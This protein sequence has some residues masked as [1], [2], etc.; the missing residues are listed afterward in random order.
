MYFIYLKKQFQEGIIYAEELLIQ[1]KKNPLLLTLLSSLYQAIDKY[2]QAYEAI[3]NSLSLNS[4]MPITWYQKGLLE[5]EDAIYNKSEM[6]F[7]RAY[8]LKSD[9]ADAYFFR[10]LSRLM[11]AKKA[12]NIKNNWAYFKNNFPNKSYHYLHLTNA[13][14]EIK[15]YEDAQKILNEGLDIFVNDPYLLNAKAFYLVDE[16]MNNTT[17][18]TQHLPNDEKIITTE[19]E[20]IKSSLDKAEEYINLA[21]HEQINAEFADTHLLVLELKNKDIL[22]NEIK[23]YEMLFPNDKLILKWKNKR[24]ATYEK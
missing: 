14:Y 11:I 9:L 7:N 13:L 3:N 1:N 15:Y 6:S 23:K 5:Y 24:L 8:M 19:E 21:L 12:E 16:I 4:F 18:V 17:V 10:M 2:E 22:I 20:K